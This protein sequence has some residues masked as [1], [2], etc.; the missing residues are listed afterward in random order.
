MPK[1]IL[2]NIFMDENVFRST[3]VPMHGMD[4]VVTQPK[5]SERVDQSDQSD[6]IIVQVEHFPDASFTGPCPHTDVHG[7]ATSATLMCIPVP[8][9]PH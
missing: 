7:G 3:R 1:N 4:A 8:H 6:H 5:A 9:L 2:D